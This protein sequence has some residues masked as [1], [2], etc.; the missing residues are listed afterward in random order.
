MELPIV[1]INNLD[2]IK[3]A[4]QKYGF[5]YVS[6]D[7]VD[8]NIVN[9]MIE[10]NK[11]YFSLQ[12]DEKTKQILDKNGLGYAPLKRVS[13]NKDKKEIKESFSYRPNQIE[14]IDNDLTKKYFDI[15]SKYSKNIFTKV[16]KSLNIPIENYVSAITP[17]FDTL[18]MIHYPKITNTNDDN[19]CGIAP[20]TDWGLLT[21]LYTSTDGLQ[22]KHDNQWFDIPTLPNHLI[23]NIADML[24][25]ISDEQYKSTL[26]Q[27]ITK[28]EKYSIAFF[29]EPN[30][31]YL[32]EPYNKSDKYKPI[33]YLDY[34]K[35]KL[36]HS[37]GVIFG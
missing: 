19:V 33:K 28:D 13:L 11:N 36:D 1:N 26:H 31:E 35:A 23:V 34:L 27:V 32:I 18:T 22:I 14:C 6:I 15:M 29:F 37:Y 17:S 4:C 7:P 30:L 10:L 9:N 5:F 2:E 12:E 24:E 16:I 25:I 3:S 20:H 8:V 21:L